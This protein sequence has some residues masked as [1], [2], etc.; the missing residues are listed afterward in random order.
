M[1]IRSFKFSILM[2]YVLINTNDQ[3][4]MP[5]NQ[6]TFDY[7]GFVGFPKHKNPQKSLVFGVRIGAHAINPGLEAVVR[8]RLQ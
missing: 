3:R 5:I 2:F 4:F 8:E 1:I 6:L 7:L